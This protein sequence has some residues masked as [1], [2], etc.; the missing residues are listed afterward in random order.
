MRSRLTSPASI[1]TRR[2]GICCAATAASRSARPSGEIRVWS[3]GCSS[4]EEAYTLADAHC[5]PP[6]PPGRLAGCA[7]PVTVDATDIDRQCLERAQAGRY[8]R[9]ALAEVPAG[10][11]PALFRGRPG[12]IAGSSNGCVERVVV[13]ALDLSTEPAATA[14]LPSHSLPECGHLLRARLAGACVRR[15]SPTRSRRAASWC[16]GRSRRSS[17]P[18]ASGSRCWT[19]GSGSIGGP[20]ERPGSW[21]SG[22]RTFAAVVADD[23]LVTVGLGSCV[24]ILLYDAEARV[25]GM[26]HILLPS[27]ALSRTDGNPAKFPQIGCAAAA[28]ADGR[29]W[30]QPSDASPPGW[31]AARACSRRWRRRA[32]SRWASGI[33]WRPDRC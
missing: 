4:G 5:R 29:R 17:A 6:G 33:W 23:M 21:W 18:P 13:R 22:W 11:G 1:A 16:W 12:R 19:R 2:P 7:R 31:P 15:L 25:G 32:R 27:P 28:R 3:A 20:H 14:E 8:R 10:A 26:A 9:E 30:R 24:A